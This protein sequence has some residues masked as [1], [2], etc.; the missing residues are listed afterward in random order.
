MASFPRFA[1]PVAREW[2]NYYR[3]IQQWFQKG[4]GPDVERPEDPLRP[5]RD[6]AKGSKSRKKLIFAIRS[7]F[8]SGLRRGSVGRSVRGPM[9]QRGL[10]SRSCD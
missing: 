10:Q 8:G 2:R 6:A 5:Y 7:S 4:S 1:S 9:T 3:S